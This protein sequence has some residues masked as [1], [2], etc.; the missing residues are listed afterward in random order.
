MTYII[1]ATLIT[2]LTGCQGS[3]SLTADKLSEL[4]NE[5][6][7]RA[8]GTYNHNGGLVLS[9]YDELQKRPGKIDAERC[10]DLEK[11]NKIAKVTYSVG[12]YQNTPAPSRY[13]KKISCQ[14]KEIEIPMTS[15][16]NKNHM[17]KRHE[18]NVPEKKK[19]FNKIEEEMIKTINDYI[20]K[21]RSHSLINPD[22]DVN[23][24]KEHYNSR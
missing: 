4:S 17:M 12:H 6:L 20:K 3:P 1:I 7:C 8:L 10:L 22:D 9:I 11:S 19:L 15:E 16:L 24:N 14:G 18:N 13:H 21:R 5:D 2:G 23:V